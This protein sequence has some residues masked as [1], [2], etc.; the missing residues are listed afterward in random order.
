M[1]SKVLVNN[2][3]CPPLALASTILD[4]IFESTADQLNLSLNFWFFQTHIIIQRQYRCMNSCIS[5][6]LAPEKCYCLF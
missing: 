1:D 2:T 5:C 6:E 4:L 3:T